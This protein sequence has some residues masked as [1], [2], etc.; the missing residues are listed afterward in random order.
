MIM[1]RKLLYLQNSIGTGPII[2]NSLQGFELDIVQQYESEQL[3]WRQYQIVMVSMLADQIHLSEISDKISNYLDGGGTLIING[4][5]AHPFL[6]E[7][8]RY[9][10]M[11]KRGLNELKIHKEVQHPLFDGVGTQ[12][13]T[14]R[15]GVSGFYGRGT[16]PPPKGAQIIHS[17]GP[18]HVAVD[19]LY[20]RPNGGRI[21]MHSGVEL[22]MFLAP[23]AEGEKNY[24]QQFFNWFSNKPEMVA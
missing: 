16:N 20:E 8:T 24:L 12:R 2:L 17:V 14:S 7:L 22:W 15:K 10:P 1:A 9:E 5:I 6:P 13:L 19:W 23:S 4:H 3:D 11:Q 21:F 18:D